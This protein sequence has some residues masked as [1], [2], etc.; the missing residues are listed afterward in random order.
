[1][2]IFDEGHLTDGTG[3]RVDFRNTV[4]ILTSNV[5]SRTAAHSSTLGYQ[6]LSSERSAEKTSAEIYRKALESHFAPEFLGRIDD[7]VCF[8]ELSTEDV[9]QIVTLELAEIF[10]RARA[11]GYNVDITPEARRELATTGYDADYGV[12]SLRRTLTK[13]VEEPLSMLIVDGQLLSG[14]NVI[15]EYTPHSGLTLR[16]A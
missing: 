14:S 1:L 8:N 2:Q 16:V 6:T 7:V 10:S 13:L 3:R 5:G 11:L 15:V 9:E 12:R 4:I